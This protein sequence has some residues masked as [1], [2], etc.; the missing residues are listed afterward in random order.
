[1][2]EL[3]ERVAVAET[4]IVALHKRLDDDI[5]I[6]KDGLEDIGKDVKSLLAWKNKVAGIVAAT[7]LFGTVFGWV[8][9]F[10]F[11]H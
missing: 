1:M 11:K 4:K 9:S 7:M 2:S 8:V 10:I 3:N 5:K 6:V